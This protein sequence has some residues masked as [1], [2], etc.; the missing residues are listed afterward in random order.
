MPSPD[1]IRRDA[2][3]V[4][5][6]SDPQFLVSKTIT[7]AA[8]TTGA[9]GATTLF[10]VTGDV[11]VRFFAVCAT[12]LT[13]SGTLEVGISGN[14]AAII[15]QTTGTAIDAGEV[16]YD[17][18]PVTVGVMPGFKILTNGTDIIQTIGT[19]TITA[20][21]ITYYCEFSPLSSDGTVVA[22]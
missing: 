19:N 20:G 22:A 21:V 11:K 14:T 4:P 13:G 17:N 5:I 15:A 18:T 7:Y 16:W 3:R 6:V 1:A 10:T 8:A 12:D 2:N 9:V